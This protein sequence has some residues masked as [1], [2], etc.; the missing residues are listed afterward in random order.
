M[1][2]IK[3]ND[4]RMKEKVDFFK[5]EK[6]KIHVTLNDKSFLNGFVEKELR[7]GVYW[8]IDDKFTNGVYLFL[9]DIYEIKEFKEVGDDF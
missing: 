2:M 4:L 9:R 8:F 7:E 6:I 3:D 1:K 5:E